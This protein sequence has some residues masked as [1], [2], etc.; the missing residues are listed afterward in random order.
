MEFA[1]GQVTVNDEP[2][3]SKLYRFCEKKIDQWLQSR[4]DPQGNLGAE[5]AEFTVSFTD[6]TEG[7]HVSCT[8]EIHVGDS[9]W[10]GWDLDSDTQQAF[11]HSLKRLQPH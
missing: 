4:L 8:T 6:E 10:R 1:N 5:S 3:K 9:V 2:T 11:I 7:K